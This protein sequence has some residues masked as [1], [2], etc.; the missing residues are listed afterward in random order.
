MLLHPPWVLSSMIL[1]F[2]QRPHQSTGETPAGT[3][4]LPKNS[5]VI[6]FNELVLVGRG[7]IYFKAEIFFIFFP[8]RPGSSQSLRSPLCISNIIASPLVVF[9]FLPLQFISKILTPEYLIRS[10]SVYDF[11]YRW[12]YKK[13][14]KLERRLGDSLKYPTNWIWTPLNQN[15]SYGWYCNDLWA[16][17]WILSY[18]LG[19]I[20]FYYYWS[21][22]FLP[23]VEAFLS[24]GSIQKMYL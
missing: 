5:V 1:R 3:L 24:W 9:L 18:F 17:L 14:G 20:T 11:H 6:L 10:I 21:L 7:F 15:H 16:S 4:D 2:W 22:L 19:L 23:I 13:F 12:N 8:L